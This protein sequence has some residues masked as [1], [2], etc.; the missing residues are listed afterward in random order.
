MRIDLIKRMYTDHGYTIDDICL[1]L[2]YQQEDVI[3]AIKKLRIDHGKK[4]WRY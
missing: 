3:A 4:S 1:R 2:R